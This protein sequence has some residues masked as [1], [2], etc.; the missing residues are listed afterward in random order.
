MTELLLL[1]ITA[2][3]AAMLWLWARSHTA[4]RVVSPPTATNARSRVDEI[5]RERARAEEVFERVE[6]GVLVFNEMLTPVLANKAARR[7]LGVRGA[8]LPAR[9]TSEGVLSVARRAVV[10]GESAEDVVSIWPGRRRLQVRAVASRHGGGV[11]VVLQ[12]ITEHLRTHQIRR[13]FVANA[14]HELKSPVASLQALA[15]AVRQA[16]GDDPHSAERFATRLVA[17]ADRLSRLIADLL[18]L[19]RLEDPATISD[20]SIDLSSIAREVIEQTEPAAREKR[21]T[22]TAQV[23]SDAW[24]RGDEHQ[25]GLLVRNLLDNAVRYTHEGGSVWV[26]VYREGDEVVVRV[27]DDG[28]GIPLQAQARVFERFYR[29]D[30]DRS[31]E[32]GGTGLGLSIV[33]HVAELHGGHVSLQ[34]ELGEG[35]TFT[36]R[37]AALSTANGEATRGVARE[38]ATRR[39]ARK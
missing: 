38:R 35:S 5:E 6:E 4:P 7:M 20:A 19:S 33:K 29:V 14:S 25:L 21:I 23:S 22:I 37:L 10:E 39:A 26:D 31:R 32:R 11:I 30:K 24:V 3:L 18:D 13:Q 9:L 36:A 16:V 15:E 17:E 2:L 12:D 8:A 27:A 1:V 28:I 34:S